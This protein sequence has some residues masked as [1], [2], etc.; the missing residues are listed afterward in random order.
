MAGL[1]LGNTGV[2]TIDEAEEAVIQV[3]PDGGG[4][5]QLSRIGKSEGG[6]LRVKDDDG[7]I[8]LYAR[9]FDGNLLGRNSAFEVDRPRRVY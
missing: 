5:S 4:S 3:L 2:E 6:S 7:S 1:Q 9:C 8:R